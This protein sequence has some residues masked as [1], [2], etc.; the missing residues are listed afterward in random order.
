MTRGSSFFLF[1]RGCFTLQ[2]T[3][4]EIEEKQHMYQD[5]IDINIDYLSIKKLLELFQAEFNTAS[6]NA[7]IIIDE[8]SVGLDHETLK[9]QNRFNN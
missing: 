3:S 7:A 9:F 6:G 2:L 1:S 8:I 5:I 4:L